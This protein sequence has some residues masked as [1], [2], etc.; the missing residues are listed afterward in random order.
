MNIFGYKRPGKLYTDI[1][2]HVTDGWDIWKVILDTFSSLSSFLTYPSA[3]KLKL[4]T[5]TTQPHIIFHLKTFR[6]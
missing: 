2:Q 4:K 5:L 6:L 3:I 1:I